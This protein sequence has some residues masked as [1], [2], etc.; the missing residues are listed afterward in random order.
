MESRS[1]THYYMG[2]N[3]GVCGFAVGFE[4]DYKGSVGVHIMYRTMSWEWTLHILT[5]PTDPIFLPVKP[6]N[7]PQSILAA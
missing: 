4:G 5:S 2:I 1:I 7:S 3:D 6:S